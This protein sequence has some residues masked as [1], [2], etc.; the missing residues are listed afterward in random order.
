MVLFSIT[1]SSSLTTTTGRNHF[2][3][4][5]DCVYL[6]LF[7][8]VLILI[9]WNFVNWSP[10]SSRSAYCSCLA[11]VMVIKDTLILIP[12]DKCLQHLYIQISLAWDWQDVVLLFLLPAS[13]RHLTGNGSQCSR[14][15]QGII[16]PPI[17]LTA[18]YPYVSQ[19]GLYRS[20]RELH[21]SAA[22][23]ETGVSNIVSSS[24]SSKGWPL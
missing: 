21:Q 19:Q 1:G 4:T 10:Y 11:D 17:F 3:S 16:R 5:H 7:G 24:I 13:G 9:A 20:F 23:V 12:N 22:C 8:P 2:L 15:S 14:I 6:F 18:L